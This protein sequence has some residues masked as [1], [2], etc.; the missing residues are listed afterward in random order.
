MFGW[1][2][3]NEIG[4]KNTFAVFPWQRAG[5]GRAET[6]TIPV[7]NDVSTNHQ[8]CN[9]LR[10]YT[11]CLSDYM[12]L[13][14]LICMYLRSR[15][16]DDVAF[17][18]WEKLLQQGRV[19][20]AAFQHPIRYALL[21]IWLI[22]HNT[23]LLFMQFPS[24]SSAASKAKQGGKKKGGGQERFSDGI[25][26]LIWPLRGCVSIK[27]RYLL[28]LIKNTRCAFIVVLWLCWWCFHLQEVWIIPS[29][30][31]LQ[32]QPQRQRR[33]L[34]VFTWQQQEMSSAA[35]RT[36]GGFASVDHNLT[37]KLR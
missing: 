2:W 26:C 3:A 8:R 23:V 36:D 11:G 9:F 4:G 27:K 10:S 34:P 19:P 22:E 1:W 6:P 15:S 7:Y 37:A 32:S 13:C 28:K 5:T 25:L 35:L 31:N 17:E 29:P 12:S 21:Q 24:S 33:R 20:G 30:P 18:L 16:D 14:C